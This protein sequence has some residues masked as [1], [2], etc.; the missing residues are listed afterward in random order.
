MKSSVIW[1]LNG[2][3]QE[4]V[5]SHIQEVKENLNG[6]YEIIKLTNEMHMNL[7]PSYNRFDVM[8]IGSGSQNLV[9]DNK[10]DRSLKININ[11]FMSLSISHTGALVF[12]KSKALKKLEI[13]G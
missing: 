6:K 11:T 3:V 4:Q 7:P 9:Q 10:S 13:D 8:L 12:M 5:F 2:S 1:R